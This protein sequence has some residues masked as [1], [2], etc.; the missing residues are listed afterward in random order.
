MPPPP[1][2]ATFTGRYARLR[3][4]PR[5]RGLCVD[6]NLN[7]NARCNFN[8]I[9][10]SVD[11]RGAQH[12]EALNVR[13]M[14]EELAAV[15]DVAASGGTA[16]FSQVKQVAISGDGEPTLCPEFAEALEGVLH[17]RALHRFSFF[18]TVVLTNATGLDRPE[19]ERSLQ[20]LT[21]RDEVWVKIDAGGQE[22][23][24]L[25]NRPEQHT[26]EQVMSNILRFSIRR[27]VVVQTLFASL[28]GHGPTDQEVDRY[29]MQL[30]RLVGE[31][32]QISG[33]QIYSATPP[34][35]DPTCGHLPLQTLSGIARTVRDATGL[36][37]EVF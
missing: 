29:A 33:V 26:F 9:Y 22:W 32:A 5:A 7:P 13:A 30:K 18:K 25:V 6:V 37:V 15:L 10:C 4:C 20:L 12:G 24:S 35:T 23:M 27:A 28:R 3:L 19:V 34:T 1:E 14:V 16:E 8:C 31:G 2:T 21:P 36:K 11:R 17:L